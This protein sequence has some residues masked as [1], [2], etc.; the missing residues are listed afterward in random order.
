MR[1]SSAPVARSAVATNDLLAGTLAL[2]IEVSGVAA[3][4]DES[5]YFE[6][7]EGSGPVE[8]LCASDSLQSCEAHPGRRTA[9]SGPDV[10]P[11]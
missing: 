2:E 8:P 5:K 1:T 9:M 10:T 7:R 3:R 4:R 11:A 6:M